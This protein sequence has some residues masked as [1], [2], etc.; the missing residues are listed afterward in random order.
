VIGPPEPADLRA[1]TTPASLGDRRYTLTVPRHWDFLLPS[2]GVVTTAALRAAA[3]AIGDAGYRLISATAIFCEPIH[4]GAV[5]LDVEVLRAGG[6]AVQTRIQLRPPGSPG[7]QVLATFAR[8]RSG[9]DVRGARMPDVPPPAACPDLL[10]EDGRNPH[11]KARF[12]HNVEC[13]LARGDRLWTPEF[14]AGPA[15]YARWFRYHHAQRDDD[16]RFDRLALAPIA[17]TMPA[18]LTQAIGP[19]SYRFFAPSLDLT[20]HVID[21]TEREWV[22]VSAYVR[23]ARAG[24]A[25]GEAELWDDEGRLLAVA[26]QAMYVRGVAGEAPVRDA[27][28]PT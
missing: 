25:I 8:D 27:T 15:R 20:L 5:E 16:G 12:F 14:R 22:L 7:A 17:D 4:P 3:A 19:G 6:A 1:D 21:D 2:G 13:R 24:W 26:S 18:A 23:R 9:P 10:V 11:L 28:D